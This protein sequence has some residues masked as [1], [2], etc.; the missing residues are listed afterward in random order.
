MMMTMMEYSGVQCVTVGS[1][2]M[3]DEQ[4]GMNSHTVMTIIKKIEKCDGDK[5]VW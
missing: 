2:L 3:T 5:K 1:N 4:L